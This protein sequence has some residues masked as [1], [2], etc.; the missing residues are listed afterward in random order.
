MKG[1]SLTTHKSTGKVSDS[2]RPQLLEQVDKA[3]SNV[4]REMGRAKS[5]V[6]V[7]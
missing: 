3:Q 1:G 6:V 7:F 4:E 2:R 5:C